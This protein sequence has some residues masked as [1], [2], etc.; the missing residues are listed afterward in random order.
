MT[1]IET[2]PVFD[3]TVEPEL[4]LPSGLAASVSEM[5]GNDHAL[6]T[7]RTHKKHVSGIDILLSRRALINGEEITSEEA[8]GLLEGDRAALLIHL[9]RLSYGDQLQTRVKCPD[10]YCDNHMKPFP[11]EATLSDEDLK[12]EPY[13]LGDTR[14]TVVE[15]GER[16][17]ELS[18]YTGD[19]S[20]RLLKMGDPH[21]LKVL[22]AR[23]PVELIQRD[24]KEIKR[25]VKLED[26][27]ARFIVELDYKIR[28]LE[29]DMSHLQICVHCPECGAEVNLPILSD[30]SFLFP[31]LT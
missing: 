5:D 17:I 20:M 31:Q 29:P 16:R 28:H 10:E 4:V 6:L 26:E 19:V 13:P 1:E 22:K 27:K 7:P 15:V 18:L 23:E 8:R 12:I 24:G 14:R 11:C 25:G 3:I 30:A 2:M 9:R 21:V